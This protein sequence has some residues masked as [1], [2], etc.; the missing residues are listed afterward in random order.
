MTDT[1]L[2]LVCKEGEKVTARAQFADMSALVKNIVEDSGVSEE[3][4]LE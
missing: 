4:P 1:T 3:I 2:T